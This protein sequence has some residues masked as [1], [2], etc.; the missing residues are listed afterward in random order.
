MKQILILTIVVLAASG[1]TGCMVGD[2]N[3]Y[4][5]LDPDGRITWTVFERN[6]R[7]IESNIET[8]QQQ[9]SQFL[10]EVRGTSHPVA[11]GFVALV[12]R[13]IQHHLL[14]DL[15]P[16]SV[17]TEARFERADDL[18]LS[19]LDLLGVQAQVDMWIDGDIT[20]LEAVIMTGEVHEE[21]LDESVLALID[22]P[23]TYEI[24]L[25]SGSF[26]TAVGFVIEE[27][28]A[29]ARPINSEETCHVEGDPLV[30]SLSWISE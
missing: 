5:Y 29:L 10:A 14:R 9:E 8:Q 12:P 28:G 30:L 27:D 7:S 16:F 4:I 22:D 21:T 25:T 23:E 19:L 26:V 1:L 3:H 2:T 15:R 18:V 20:T 11:L 13:S 6:V 24:R 17:W